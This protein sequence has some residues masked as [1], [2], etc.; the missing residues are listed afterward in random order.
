[1]TTSAFYHCT[2]VGG[3]GREQ[4]KLVFNECIMQ[5]NVVCQ[6]MF[7]NITTSQSQQKGDKN[8]KQE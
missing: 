4:D 2:G 1:M 7:G 5:C 8:N 6:D 3:W